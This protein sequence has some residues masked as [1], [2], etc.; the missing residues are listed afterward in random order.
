MRKVESIILS[1]GQKVSISIDNSEK[2]EDFIVTEYVSFLGQK[3]IKLQNTKIP[4]KTHEVILIRL[5]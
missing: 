4:N 3:M 2:D 5:K 1:L